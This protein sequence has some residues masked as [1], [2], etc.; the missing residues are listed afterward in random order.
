MIQI[1]RRIAAVIV[2]CLSLAGAV[3]AQTG[4]VRLHCFPFEKLAPAERREAEELLLKALD[5]EAL[6]TIVGGVKPMSSGFQSFRL[7][8]SLPR[9]GQAEAAKE[10]AE[11]GA[12]KTEE[13]SDEQK[14]RL[15]QAKQ[16]IERGETLEKIE[17]TR[18]I[19]DKWRCGDA[20]NF[21]DVQ[22]FARQFEGRR[23]F[24][25]VVFSRPR[26][27]QMLIEKAD[28]FSRWG[29]T[30]NSHPL[31]VLY[32]VEY[33]ETTA[34]NAGYGYL[35]GYPDAA[36]RFFVEAANEEDL[37]GRFVERDFYSIPTFARETNGFVYAVPKNYAEKEADKNLRARATRILA[38]Y[39]KRR[40]EY[41][42]EGKPGVVELL[43]DWFCQ[44]DKCSPQT[45]PLD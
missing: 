9:V 24:D 4:A 19:L 23:F 42:G 44:Q 17:K 3:L 5:G 21:A 43:R 11:L 37:T 18:R 25:A 15:N 36:V 27:R 12:K 39:K 7:Q 22:H 13:L 35:F 14:R 40:A 8:T 38:A 30:E 34:R 28:F 32:A 31:H 41:V 16:A 6:Y 10:I 2:I 20:E 1:Y 45:A 29:V 33:E 26:L